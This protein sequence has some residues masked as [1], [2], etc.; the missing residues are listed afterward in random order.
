M[1]WPFT[2]KRNLSFNKTIRA[3]RTAAVA[4]LHDPD[5][6]ITLNPLVLSKTADHSNPNLFIITDQ[7]VILGCIHTTTTYK[8]LFTNND[9]G[10]DT[11]VDAGIGTKLKGQWRAKDGQD[12]TS[13]V[14]EEPEVEVS[15]SVKYQCQSH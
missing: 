11:D 14:S 10:V 13:E 7:L 3:P 1:V 12:E 15:T 8:C 2:L 6:L 4:F 5:N 9:K